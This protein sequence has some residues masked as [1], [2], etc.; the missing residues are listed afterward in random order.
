VILFY[1]SIPAVP[2][3]WDIC[4]QKKAPGDDDGGL[5]DSGRADFL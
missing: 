2:G 4:K 1:F 5:A 3:N